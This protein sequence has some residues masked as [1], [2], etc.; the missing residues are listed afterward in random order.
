MIIKINKKICTR[1]RD[2]CDIHI[3]KKYI[4]IRGEIYNVQNTQDT[5]A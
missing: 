3:F 5:L 4:Y 2:V 1:R